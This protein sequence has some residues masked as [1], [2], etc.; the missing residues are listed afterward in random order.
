[1]S[2]KSI[3]L[4]AAIAAGFGVSTA[5]AQG[6]GEMGGER[7]SFAELDTD[8]DGT[9]SEAELQ[10]P[11]A[12]RFAAA[13][14]DGDGNLTAEEI[15][16]MAEGRRADRMAERAERMIAR[17]DANEDGV[18]SAEELATPPAPQSAFERLD[19][20]GDGTISEEEFAAAGERGGDRQ[21]GRD[22]RGE[23]RGEGHGHGSRG[24][25]F[26]QRG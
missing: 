12:E 4:I 14:A 17:F 22:G 25:F 15:V 3:L 18:L 9:L 20:D 21:R 26:G 2:N 6:R 11:M 10:A 1:M 16:A 7:P 5:S 8:G 13:D 24:G 19:A 23:G